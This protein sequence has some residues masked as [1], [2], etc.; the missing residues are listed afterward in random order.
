VSRSRNNGA[1]FPSFAAL[2]ARLVACVLV[3]CATLLAAPATAQP[4]SQSFVAPTPVPARD[5]GSGY[6]G[7]REA[8]IALVEGVYFLDALIE[9][10]LSSEAVEAL[11]A[12]VPL[13]I[14]IDMYVTSPRRFWFDNEEAKLEQRFE[15]LY[16]AVSER[17]L[18]R[19]LNSGEIESFP[20][21]QTALTY[22]GRIE[23]LPIIDADLLDA[24]ETYDLRFKTA[25]DIEKF[26]GPLRLLAFWRRDWS[27]GSDWYQWRLPRD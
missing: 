8:R 24:D 21:L 16:R 25:L 11:L 7:A 15:L 6:F 13:T 3:C 26:P 23:S 17:F 12:G 5:D 20:T 2:G 18:V 10:R 19:N 27:L 4:V 9:Y 14:E 22:L 1:S